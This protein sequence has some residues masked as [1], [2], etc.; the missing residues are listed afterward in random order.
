[1][2]RKLILQNNS[3]ATHI[4]MKSTMVMICNTSTK[5]KLITK[6]II[7]MTMNTEMTMIMIM[8]IKMSM[9]MQTIMSMGTSMIT[10]M[11]IWMHIQR[12][13][14]DLFLLPLEEKMKAMIPSVKMMTMEIKKVTLIIITCLRNLIHPFQTRLRKS[15]KAVIYYKKWWKRCKNLKRISWNSSSNMRKKWMRSKIKMQ[16]DL[17]DLLG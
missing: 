9:T 4:E 2:I 15:Y 10:T 12:W 1:M 14:K 8:K 5:I 16:L 6:E 7:N 3:T 17:K 11:I 13:S